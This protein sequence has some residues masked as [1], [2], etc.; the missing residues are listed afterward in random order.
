[1]VTRDIS[2][3]KRLTAEVIE[4]LAWIEGVSIEDASK[5]VLIVTSAPEHQANVAKLDAVDQ[6][7]NPV[8]GLRL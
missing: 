3:C 1:M 4:F 6:P 2:M 7:N 5:K 8:D